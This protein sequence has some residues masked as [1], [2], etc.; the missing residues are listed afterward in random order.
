V[1]K[2]STGHDHNSG[3]APAPGGGTLLSFGTNRV[4]GGNSTV[5]L[6]RLHAL[7]HTNEVWRVS[8]A[9]VSDATGNRT[10]ATTLGWG[11]YEEGYFTFAPGLWPS[12]L[13]WALRCEVTRTEGF[14]PGEIF[15]FRDVPLGSLDTTNRVG[16]MTNLAGVTVTLDHII[17][18]APNTNNSWSSSD[19]SHVKFTTAG[20]GN[21]I[22]LDLLSTR[23]DRGTNV[24]PGSWSSSGGERTYD[25][26]TLPAKAKTADFTFA[27]QR[28]HWVEFTL[29]PEVGD[30]KVMIN[31]RR[32]R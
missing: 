6:I 17:R 10:E 13:A 22:H 29:K 2:L 16:W 14:A 26:R 19:V 32:K 21:G 3:Y 9:E 12:E 20:V 27:V 11:N 18:R 5:C 30:A 24:D 7:T 8:G 23:T 31:P 25:F 15:T 28:S 4:D 1:E